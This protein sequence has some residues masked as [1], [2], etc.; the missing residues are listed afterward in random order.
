MSTEIKSTSNKL[1]SGYFV[2]T[3][4]ALVALVVGRIEPLVFLQSGLSVFPWLLLGVLALIGTPASVFLVVA[5]F[6]YFGFHKSKGRKLGVA[7]FILFLAVSLLALTF[8]QAA[9]TSG[10]GIAQYFAIFLFVF[11]IQVIYG[12]W[13]SEPISSRPSFRTSL[14]GSFALLLIS[15]IVIFVLL[16]REA[17][18]RDPVPLGLLAGSGLFLILMEVFRFKY[19]ARSIAASLCSLA[20]VLFLFFTFGFALSMGFNWDPDFSWSTL[21]S[22]DT[23]TNLILA[24]VSLILFQITY[25]ALRRRNNRLGK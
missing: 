23:L 20:L 11:S 16:G 5:G 14:A 9:A 2:W 1:R 18:Y 22:A 4:V 24:V 7:V 17:T 13:S 25:V 12:K 3:L 10:K 15:S 19:V 21:T 8:Y 6:F